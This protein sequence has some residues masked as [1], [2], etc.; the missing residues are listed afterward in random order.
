MNWLFCLV[1]FA[2]GFLAAY[3]W[4]SRRNSDSRV[5]ELES[6]LTSLQDKYEQYQQGV[7]GHFAHTAQLVNNLT[8]AYREV[9]EHLQRGA[10]E[11]C[12]DNQRHTA[13]NPASAFIALE[14]PK[15]AYPQAML[16]DDKF[17]ATVMPP[18]D[19]ATKQPDDKGTLDEE[20][21]LK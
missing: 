15:E 7:T 1:S 21:G 16:N 3:V 9:H 20:Y 17:L 12:A 13:A 6:H 2:A 14:A 18:R 8:N 5:K 19:Y 4:L 10:G 11:L